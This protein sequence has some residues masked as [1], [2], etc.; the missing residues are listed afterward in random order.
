MKKLLIIATLMTSFSALSA[1][2]FG[3]DVKKEGAKTAYAKNGVSVSA[4]IR[5]ALTAQ[6]CKISINVMTKSEIDG[7]K[8]ENAKRRYE[9]LLAAAKTK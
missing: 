6:G 3:L 4:K 8:L 7:M 5:E 2:E 1:C 9:K